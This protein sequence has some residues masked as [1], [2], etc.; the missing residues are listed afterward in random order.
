MKIPQLILPECPNFS[1]GPTKKPDG[2]SFNKLN[3]KF[4]GRYH[5]S[6][7]VK[8]Y[9]NDIINTVRSILKVPDEYDLKILPGSATGAMESVIWSFL[10]KEEVSS[11][12]YD[13]WG[14]TWNNA[15]KKKNLKTDSRISLDGTIPTLEKIPNNNDILIVWTG[16]STGMSINQLEE[17]S[18]VH[19]GLVICDLTSATFIYDIP[20]QKIDVSVFSWQ[21]A[22]GSEAQ[23][24]MIT[25]SP[26]AKERLNKDNKIP[27][28]MDIANHDFLINTP[29]LLSISDLEL[30]LK[31]YQKRGTLKDNQRLCKEN[32]KTIDNWVDKNTFV[33]KFAK[34]KEY[35]ALSSVYLIFNKEIN[36]EK[37]FEFLFKNRIAFDI[38]NYRKA[39]KG[40]RFWIGPTIKK[41]DLIALTNWLD[42]CFKNFN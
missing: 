38:K 25:I 3:K 23:H 27:K 29:S 20:W 10:G 1:C 14:I 40:I 39:P 33:K 11:I 21:K 4:L 19:E 8:Q 30:C 15:L 26:K 37:L 34:K 6:D 13:Y 18:E 5:R 16:T 28:I 41:N 42:W 31:L 22:L 7:D 35:E 9:I 12:I 32:K 17:L 24:G 2:W 36:S